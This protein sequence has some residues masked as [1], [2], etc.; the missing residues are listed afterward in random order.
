MLSSGVVATALTAIIMFSACGSDKSAN[1]D[2]RH[3]DKGNTSQHEKS[4]NSVV[5]FAYPDKL[6][7]EFDLCPIWHDGMNW[8]DLRKLRTHLDRPELMKYVHKLQASEYLASQGFPIIPIIHKSYERSDVI[9]ILKTHSSFVAKPAHMSQNHGLMVVVEGFD[10]ISKQNVSAESVQ[11]KLHKLLET[12]SN[13]D[14]ALHRKMK[15]AFLIQEYIKDSYEIKY[16]TVWGKVMA[17]GWT[18]LGGIESGYAIYNR[19]GLPLRSDTP[20]LDNDQKELYQ[21]GIELAERVA[22]KSD[23][24][25]IDIMI[26]YNDNGSKPDLFV[27]ELELRSG[28]F[29]PN[30]EEM[31]QAINDGY[32]NNCVISSAD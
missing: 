1:T 4:K 22:E 7:P 20:Q 31:A 12:T 27:N 14:E 17:G 24:L 5:H 21:R 26:R 19:E 16:E 30:M 32:R 25:R 3:S 6:K 2:T 18:K 29:P 23:F 8:M 9:D 13:S 10:I 15:P 28:L 11:Q